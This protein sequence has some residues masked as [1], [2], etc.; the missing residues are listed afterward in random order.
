MLNRATYAGFFLDWFFE[1]A[2][3]VA[4]FIAAS[5]SVS[6]YFGMFCD[7]DGMVKDAR[8]DISAY[9]AFES[10]ERS[11][12][13]NAWPIYVQRIEFHGGITK[14]AHILNVFVWF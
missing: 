7:I 10:P 12:D 11:S 6:L 2:A 9:E 3:I 5:A 8:N 13:A 14:Y 1:A 4:G